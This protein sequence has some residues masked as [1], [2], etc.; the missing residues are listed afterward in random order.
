[1]VVLSF[2]FCSLRNSFWSIGPSHNSYSLLDQNEWGYVWL[3]SDIGPGSDM[4]STKGCS[5]SH[6]IYVSRG[7]NTKNVWCRKLG[8][9]RWRPITTEGLHHTVNEG[10]ALCLAPPFPPFTTDWYALYLLVGG[11]QRAFYGIP[12]SRIFTSEEGG[13]QSSEIE[14]LP[15]NLA[16]R[17]NPLNSKAIISF[18]LPEPEKLSLTIYDLSGRMVK[19]LFSGELPGGNHSFLWNRTDE[20]GKEALPGIYFLLLKTRET[21]V[22]EKIIIR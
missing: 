21:Q 22:V 7:N 16:I 12:A 3:P 14:P 1:M 5:F 4:T 15:F 11:R 8:E 6:F 9:R 13:G 17:P 2:A 18:F 19:N 10:G 20:N